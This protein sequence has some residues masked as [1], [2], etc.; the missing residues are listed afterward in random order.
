MKAT[1]K[2]LAAATLA[3]AGMLVVVQAEAADRGQRGSGASGVARGGQGVTHGTSSGYRGSGN[4]WR[5][6][7][8]RGHGHWGGYR[9]WP[10][11]RWGFYY[12]VPLFLG[13]AYGWPYYYD[14]DRYY[15][16]R[17][18]VIYRDAEP[19]P[20]SFPEGEIGPAPATTEVPRGEGA[21]SRGP[22][23]MNYCESA[24]AYFPKVTTCPEGWRL[25]T[26]S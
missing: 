17:S 21:P 18:A 10:G 2:L 22:L 24:K 26:P 3:A 6:S 23:Y 8:W 1:G 4:H 12:G 20:Q 7:N 9:Y 19:Y 25:A 16:P 14:Y 5:G 13:A 15:Y 11:S